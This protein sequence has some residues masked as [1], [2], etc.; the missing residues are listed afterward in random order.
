[1]QISLA[2]VIG[3]L[4]L[5]FLSISGIYSDINFQLLVI[6]SLIPAIVGIYALIMRTSEKNAATKIVNLTVPSL[7][8]FITILDF[9]FLSLILS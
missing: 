5:L 2:G 4:S 9:Y 1:M 7:V 6:A 8:I 3:T